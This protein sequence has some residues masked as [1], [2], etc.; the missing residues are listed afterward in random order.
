M[1]IAGVSIKTVILQF[2]CPDKPGLVSDLAS[3]IASKNG[4]IRHADHHTDSDAKL[5]LSRIEWD[6]EGFLLDK[7]E[8]N[9]EVILLEQRLNGKAVLSFSEDFPNVAIF[10]SKQSHCLVDLLWRVKAGELC[11]NIP[12]V[13]SNHS[14]LEELCASFSIPFKLIKVDKN[15][16]ADS[17]SKILDLL[18]EYKIDLGVL[19][20]YMQILSS[21]FLEKFPHFINIHHSFLPAF[22]GA[23]PYHQAWERG[24]KLIGA[25]AHYVTEDLDAGPIIEQTISNVSHRDEVTDLIRKGRDL[26]RVALARALRLHLRRQVIVYKGRTAVFT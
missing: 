25:T 4:N 2:I 19:A 7:N 9:S 6:L 18:N 22:K 14:D 16:K 17:E 26:E 12:L 21:S 3:W 13:I 23:Q 24:V 8:I 20:K 10:V 11:M 1:D 5:F 15:N